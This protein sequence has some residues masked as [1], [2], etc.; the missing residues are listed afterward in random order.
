MYERSVSV[1]RRFVVGAIFF[2]SETK[3]IK[4]L[5]ERRARRARRRQI[6]DGTGCNVPAANREKIENPYIKTK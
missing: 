3:K 6:H 1:F 2:E 4:P 5:S